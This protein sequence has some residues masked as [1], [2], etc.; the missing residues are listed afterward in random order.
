V[1]ADARN[2][3]E[4]THPTLVAIYRYWDNKR[5]GRA[6]PQRADIDPTEIVRLLPYIFMVDVERDPLRFRYR[7][8]GTAICEFLGRDFTGR[9]VD[10][11]NYRPEQAAEL[12]KINGTVVETARPVGCKGTLFYVPGREWLLT[13][14]IL[15]PLGKDGIN[16]DIIFGGQVASRQPKGA[17]DAPEP[18]PGI[19]IIPNPVIAG[20]ASGGARG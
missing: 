10:A 11:T 7:L 15:L 17:E 5:R 1:A 2:S 6:M 19:R 14:A 9:M 8:I 12:Q 3:D 16:V 20:E 4:I 13:E 18:V